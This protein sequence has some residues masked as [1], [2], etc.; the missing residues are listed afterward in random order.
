MRSANLQIGISLRIVRRLSNWIQ[1]MKGDEN[2]C[3]PICGDT[4]RR[5]R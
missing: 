1:R 5:R 4:G 3:R 2:S